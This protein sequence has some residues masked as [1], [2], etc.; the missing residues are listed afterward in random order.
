MVRVGFPAKKLSDA[1]AQAQW[2]VAENHAL[3]TQTISLSKKKVRVMPSATRVCCARL[4]TFASILMLLSLGGISCV[5]AQ[6]DMAWSPPINI[7]QSIG[8]SLWPWLISDESGA[9]H[10]FWVDDVGGVHESGRPQSV[11]T[12]MYRFWRDGVWSEPRDV[13]V[14]PG[15]DYAAAPVAAIDRSGVLHVVWSSNNGI[16]Y[17]NADSRFA[18]N[19][20]AWRT[21]VRL[22][23]R[24]PSDI[25]PAAI[26]VDPEDHI[27][28]VVASPEG[29]YEVVHVSSIDGGET[30][31][32]PTSVSAVMDDLSNQVL[33]SSTIVLK[34]DEVG[35]LHVAWAMYD[36][37]GFGR[38]ILY[39][40]STDAGQNWSAP[41]VLGTR[42]VG[43]YSA[44]WPVMAS[45]GSSEVYLV[46]VGQGSPPGR[47][48]RFSSDGGATWSDVAPVMEGYRGGNRGL[49]M[50][51]DSA[52]ALYL[53]SS[54][55]LGGD[56]TTV[57]NTIGRNGIWG[58]VT[59]IDPTFAGQH[60]VTAA[61]LGGNHLF[62]AWEEFVSGEIFLSESLVDA[63]AI[64]TR[65]FP[66]RHPTPGPK[67]DIRASASSTPLPSATAIGLGSYS[68]TVP[69]PYSNHVT[70]LILATVSAGV[71]VSVV[72]IARI[73]R[74]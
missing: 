5:Q 38:A 52:N 65:Q 20:H 12:I 56:D 24:G 18:A 7:S 28:V 33:A 41:L 49:A 53:F 8:S 42:E 19:P 3:H 10:L 69:Q 63:P 1:L 64:L 58:S 4:T 30:W 43:D 31:S 74:R 9:L 66:V 35:K 14:S 60:S 15:G 72:L 36:Q 39:S 25:Y 34:I 16:Y 62:V 68:T 37:E 17:S 22:A 50:A 59:A 61:V 45:V 40:S 26:A 70:A 27:H 47:S 23:L 48:Y 11:N 46:W 55:R 13:L 44:E 67:P 29:G 57:R 21:V 2:P 54:A 32:A 71:L 51:V 6:S 73:G